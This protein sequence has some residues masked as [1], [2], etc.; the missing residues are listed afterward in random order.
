MNF[1]EIEENTAAHILRHY[2]NAPLNQDYSCYLCYPIPPVEEI[3]QAFRN[4][5]I[6]LNYEFQAESFTSCTVTAFNI[7]E[8]LFT[9]PPSEYRT[10]QITKVVTKLLISIR[11]KRLFFSFEVPSLYIQVLASKSNCYQIPI[12]L[13][14]S[15]E[16]FQELLDLELLSIQQDRQL[17]QQILSSL[18]LYQEV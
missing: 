16:A 12:T 17:I 1:E 13:P 9:S 3:S 10:D 2:T 11:Y 7:F 5:W 4:F 15:E 14:I 8:T 6:W 18:H